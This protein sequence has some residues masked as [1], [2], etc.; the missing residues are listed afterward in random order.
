MGIIT[1]WTLKSK[2]VWIIT[3]RY[4]SKTFFWLGVSGI[5]INIID[6]QNVAPFINTIIIGIIFIF[7]IAISFYLYRHFQGEH[8][9]QS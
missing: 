1:P 6:I 8:I 3:H 5:V 7:P 9:F 2:A 4:T